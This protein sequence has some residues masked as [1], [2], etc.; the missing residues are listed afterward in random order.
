[1]TV[2]PDLFISFYRGVENSLMRSEETD[3]KSQKCNNNKRMS[4]L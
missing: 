2:R 4:L 3:I 1:M